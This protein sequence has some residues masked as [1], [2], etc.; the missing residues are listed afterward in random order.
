[1]KSL[2]VVHAIALTTLS[3]LGLTLG[4]SA[5]ESAPGSSVAAP[6]ESTGPKDTASKDST[7]EESRLAVWQARETKLLAALKEVI[8]PQSESRKA[9]TSVDWNV[10]EKRVQELVF[11][12]TIADEDNT[13]PEAQLNWVRKAEK[14]LR[15]EEKHERKEFA[16]KNELEILDLLQA[17]ILQDVKRPGGDEPATVDSP[18]AQ[19]DEALWKFRDKSGARTTK[20]RYKG[21]EPVN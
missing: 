17:R 12:E 3:A 19:D 10:V 6:L 14:S 18:S 13:W 1:M 2:A 5:A 16:L 21:Q 15:R 11:A 4:A 20:A 9:D 8:T 7:S